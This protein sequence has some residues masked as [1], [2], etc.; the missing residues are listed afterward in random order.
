MVVKAPQPGFR[1]REYG[2]QSVTGPPRTKPGPVK[3]KRN[4]TL[5]P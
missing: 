4:L 5:A 1:Y 2:S 3:S